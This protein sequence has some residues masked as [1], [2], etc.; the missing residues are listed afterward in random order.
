MVE[1]TISVSF[2]TGALS[3]LQVSVYKQI[4][5]NCR[6]APLCRKKENSGYT[7]AY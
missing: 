1:R 6:L 2:R 7:I 3:L 4:L 5:R